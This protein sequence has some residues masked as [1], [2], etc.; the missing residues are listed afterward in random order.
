MC[1]ESYLLHVPDPAVLFRKIRDQRM[2]GAS[3]RPST[4]RQDI[5]SLGGEDS[6]AERLRGWISHQECNVLVTLLPQQASKTHA[7][8]PRTQIPMESTDLQ[9]NSAFWDR[10][11]SFALA[12]GRRHLCRH[13]ADGAA[14]ARGPLRSAACGGGKPHARVERPVRRPGRPLGQAP[15]GGRE[16]HPG[17][18]LG[19]ERYNA[20]SP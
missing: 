13:G 10:R 8:P 11:R 18:S 7:R 20:E 14:A 3:R 9:G 1:W 5:P 15:C 19:S 6:L 16:A 4:Y 12:L 2:K 17:C